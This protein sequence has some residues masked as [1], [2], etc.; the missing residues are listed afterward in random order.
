MPRACNMRAVVSPP[1]PPPTMMTFMTQ[2]TGI[3]RVRSAWIM[4]RKAD[5]AQWFSA[6]IVDGAASPCGGL[7]RGRY[8]SGPTTTM[9]GCAGSVVDAEPAMAGLGHQPRE[10]RLVHVN[11]RH[12]VAALQ[13]D[14]WPLLH[15]VVDDDVQ[16]VTLA[17]RRD[18][19]ERAVRKQRA[20]L[21]FIRQV[22]VVA[23][24]VPQIG[25][26]DVVRGRQD[27]EQVAA[28]VAQYD[29]L[30]EALARDVAG[31]GGTR[32]G[33]RRFV[34]DH[35]IG[36]VAVEMSLKYRGDGHN[37]PPCDARA[38]T[39]EGPAAGRRLMMHGRVM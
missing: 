4:V 14:V 29:G 25:E 18:R 35:L 31:L 30:G 26:A 9:A 34:R 39:H 32:R 15:A 5:P 36:D 3:T 2:L 10:L 7:G 20:D 21:L 24:L 11:Q 33:H 6:E 1:I 12:V 38:R 19:A 28:V 27:G 37:G 13:V 16:T 8:L 17:D 23:D 22:D